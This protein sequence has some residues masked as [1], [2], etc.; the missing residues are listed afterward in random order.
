MFINTCQ[1]FW[2]RLSCPYQLSA[3]P[4]MSGTTIRCEVVEKTIATIIFPNWCRF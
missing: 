3:K 1:S 4:G 2:W